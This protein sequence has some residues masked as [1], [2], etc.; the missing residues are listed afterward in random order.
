MIP[1]WIINTP[2]S[3]LCA[4]AYIRFDS[5]QQTMTQ[6]LI[7]DMLGVHREGVVDAAGKLQK[8]GL[9]HYSRGHIAA[10]DRP[11]LETQ[12]F[13]C[14]AVVKHQYD[15]LRSI[16]RQAGI[17]SE[18][19][20]LRDPS[21]PTSKRWSSMP[22]HHRERHRTDRTGWLRV[23]SKPTPPATIRHSRTLHRALRS[24]SG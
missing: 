20:P 19:D 24:S 14:Y 23:A 3:N 17:A 1:V 10:L 4:I 22:V 12:V 5:N 9:I 2:F 16:N 21:V 11:K 6:G 7:A 13:D 8:A 15:R 18:R